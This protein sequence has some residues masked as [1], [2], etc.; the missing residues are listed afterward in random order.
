MRHFM[1]PPSWDLEYQSSKMDIFKEL[2]G[3]WDPEIKEWV[4]DPE[5]DTTVIED[6]LEVYEYGHHEVLDNDLTP[7]EVLS[8]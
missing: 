2:G 6:W 5:I 4:I 8:D 7:T 1:L 3:Q